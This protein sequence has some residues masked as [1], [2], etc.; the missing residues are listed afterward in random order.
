MGIC[1]TFQYGRRVA[2]NFY[3]KYFCSNLISFM[4]LKQP[5]TMKVTIS[6]RAYSK[7]LLH[8]SKYPHKAVCGVVIARENSDSKIDVLDAVPLFHLSLG[9][10]PMMEVALTQ[11]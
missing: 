1:C 7:I 9:L 8:A 5:N 6:S 4:I 3:Y 10:A 11:V 2:L